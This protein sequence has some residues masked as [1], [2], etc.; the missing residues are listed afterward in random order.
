VRSSALSF[1]SARSPTTRT[2]DAVIVSIVSVVSAAGDEVALLHAPYLV[3]ETSW[4][5]VCTIPATHR[6]SASSWTVRSCCSGRSTA[7]SGR[8]WPTAAR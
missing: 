3:G 7:R 4:S 1:S 5:E 8:R 6:G 2:P